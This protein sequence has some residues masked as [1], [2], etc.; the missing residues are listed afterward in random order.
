MTRTRHSGRFGG[1]QR[2]RGQSGDSVRRRLDD[3]HAAAQTTTAHIT[4]IAT[5]TFEVATIEAVRVG[6]TSQLDRSGSGSTTMSLGSARPV[7]TVDTSS[8]SGSYRRTA[9]L[10]VSATS[11]EPSARAHTPSGC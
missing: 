5:T 8:R 4:A 3:K 1:S 11:T 6:T 10:Y 2:S 7:A 9:P